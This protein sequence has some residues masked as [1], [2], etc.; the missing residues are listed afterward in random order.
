MLGAVGAG[1]VVLLALV[2]LYSLHPLGLHGRFPVAQ[3]IAFKGV[4][5]FGLLAIGLLLGGSALAVLL[6]GSRRDR[7]RATVGVGEADDSDDSDGTDGRVVG[8]DDESVGGTRVGRNGAVS[9]DRASDQDPDQ[10]QDAV[11]PRFPIRRRASAVVL[12]GAIAIA[13]AGS[14]HAVS[15]L[16]RGMR[17]GEVTASG[18]AATSSDFTVMTVN[19]ARSR[20]DAQAVADLAVRTGSDVLAMPETTVELAGRVRDLI[21]ASAGG[22][23]EVYSN[24]EGPTASTSMIVSADLGPYEQVAMGPTGGFGRVHLVPI[25]DDGR[26]PV[27]VAAHPP[28]PVRA[29]MT[30][31]RAENIGIVGLCQRATRPTVIAGDL[32]MTVDHSVLESIGDQMSVCRDA[33]IDARIGGVG[34]WPS[35]VPAWAGTVIDHVLVTGGLR[36]DVGEVADIPGSDHRAVV[37]SLRLNG[38]GDV[39]AERRSRLIDEG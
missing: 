23:F 25:G 22:Q 18:E 9:P 39:E 3:I 12:A 29:N 6:L 34:T 1:A 15:L 26:Q 5:A 13:F 35:D 38:T 2:A 27:L 30:E 19:M 14:A 31:W 28:P 36:G 21:E 24:G 32:N 10:D 4:L 7:A 33:G 16:D 8:A 17:S 20:A 11:P 37:V